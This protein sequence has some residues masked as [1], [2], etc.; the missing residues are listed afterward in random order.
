MDIGAARAAVEPWI[1]L[2]VLL[3]IAGLLLTG[4]VALLVARRRTAPRGAAPAQRW[5]DDDLPGFLATPPGSAPPGFAQRP[6]GDTA[7][8]LA[9]PAPRATAPSRPAPPSARSLALGAAALLLVA[10]VVV[11][12]VAAA[13]PRERHGPDRDG[14]ADRGDA[15]RPGP[16][17]AATEA[18]LTFEGVVL[19]ERAV[20]V[21]VTYPELVLQGGV[22]SL[23][24]PTWNCLASE[25]PD[26][27][28]AEGCAAGRTEYAELGAP[29]L[30]VTRTGDGLRLR[31]E[32]ATATRPTSGADEPTGR[33]YDLVVTV[34]SDGRARP[35]RWTPAN[36]ELELGGRQAASVEG[37]LRLGR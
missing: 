17:G 10:T 12:A 19:E 16:A 9:V 2:G 14:R 22:A 23:T 30:A 15:H 35:G 31:G 7:V 28:V 3:G 1:A 37:E 6:A 11:A 20:G 36:G 18:R 5:P 24:L 21:T 4:L 33:A 8:P 32:F 27:P 26:D 13:V 29:G 25:A 34:T